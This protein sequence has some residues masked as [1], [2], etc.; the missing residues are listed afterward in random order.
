M[1]KYFNL[2]IDGPSGAGKSTIAKLVAK[3]LNFIYID[4]GAMYRAI[5]LFFL[6]KNINVDNEEEINKYIDDINVEFRI[7]DN[8]IRLF[9]NDEDI[10]DNIRT[11]EVS[12]G[13]SRVSV[14]AKVRE[15]MVKMQQEMAQKNN[16]VMDGRDIGTVVLPN[17]DLKI[18]LTASVKERAQRRF[19]ELQESGMDVQL[20]QIEKDI[21]E[22]DYRDTHRDI[23]PLREAE[24]AVHLNSDGMKIEEEVSYILELIKSKKE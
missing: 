19:R 15:R 24:D 23:S 18:Y 8:N 16:V 1:E 10:T 20:E 17:A 13:A 7:I 6:K 11:P 12:D 4:T 14:H 21:E 9:L 22:R 3:E 2:A 5:A